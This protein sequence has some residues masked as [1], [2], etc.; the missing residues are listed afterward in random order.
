MES[1][2]E[3]ILIEKKEN[4][5]RQEGLVGDV[6]HGST[7]PTSTLVGSSCVSSVGAIL[8]MLRDVRGSYF[9]L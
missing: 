2:I 7:L 9:F 5:N 8:H 1:K 3:K 4:E 6:F